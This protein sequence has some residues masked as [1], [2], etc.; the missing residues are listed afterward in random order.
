M[1]C[2]N[3]HSSYQSLKREVAITFLVYV[4]IRYTNKKTRTSP[5]SA[6]TADD[7]GALILWNPSPILT[8]ISQHCQLKE[9]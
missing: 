5:V 1:F 6:D 2:L 4:T 9:Q 7:S 8:N 3:A